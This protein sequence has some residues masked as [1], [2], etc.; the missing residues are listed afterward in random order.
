MSLAGQALQWGQ[1]EMAYLIIVGFTLFLRTG[2]LLSLKSQ[3]I[4]INNNRGVVYLAPSKG[5]KRMFLPLE[6]V[7]ILEQCTR[8]ALRK[9][10]RNKQPGDLP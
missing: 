1:W 5:A 7:E 4:I 10:R 8:D 2:E 3:D 6:R 9:L